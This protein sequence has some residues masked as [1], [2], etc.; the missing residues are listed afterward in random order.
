M[1][2]KSASQN[3]FKKKKVHQPEN[4]T[5]ANISGFSANPLPGEGKQPTVKILWSK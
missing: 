1:K 2:I 3:L 5:H 4:F